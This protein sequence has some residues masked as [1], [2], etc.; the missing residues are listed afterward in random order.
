MMAKAVISPQ[1][2]NLRIILGNESGYVHNLT[3]EFS[4]DCELNH[5]E[6]HHAECQTPNPQPK[7]E[8]PNQRSR[9][10]CI[11]ANCPA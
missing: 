3:C 11:Q 2:R 5:A 6:L 9:R 10:L 4:N 8:T 1:L 7:D